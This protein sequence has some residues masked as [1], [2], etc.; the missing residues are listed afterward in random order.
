[1]DCYGRRFGKLDSCQTCEW[2]SYCKDAAD[3]PVATNREFDDSRRSDGFDGET[4]EEEAY[5]E[6]ELEEEIASTTEDMDMAQALKD[7]FIML[8]RIADG[9]ETRLGIIMDRIAGRSYEWIAK[10][11][12]LTKQAIEKHMKVIRKENAELYR[13]LLGN[14]P[15]MPIKA[16][17]TGCQLGFVDSDKAPAKKSAPGSRKRREAEAQPQL[18]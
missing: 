12:N 15:R 1:M 3:L 17:E 8:S 4:A 2:A 9:S 5:Q 11:R 13:Y 7:A 18:F 14:G 6:I 10:K 16:I